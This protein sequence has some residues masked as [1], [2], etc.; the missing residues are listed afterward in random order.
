MKWKDRN[1]FIADI[2]MVIEDIEKKSEWI[3]RMMHT[4]IIEDNN[5]SHK[6]E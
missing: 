3:Y 2:T 1:F 4:V 6:T 5:T